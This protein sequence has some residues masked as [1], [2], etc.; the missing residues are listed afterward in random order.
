MS[1]YRN[2]II[3]SVL[4]LFA[5][6]CQNSKNKQEEQS[7]ESIVEV[8]YEYGIPVDSFDMVEGSVGKGETLSAIFGRL[9]CNGQVI[10]QLNDFSTE[11]FDVKRIKQGGYVTI[12]RQAQLARH[13]VGKAHGGYIVSVDGN[14]RLVAYLPLADVYVIAVS[15]VGRPLYH[16]PFIEFLD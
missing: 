9:G 11:F 16:A 3:I 1:L 13:L 12:L 8:V 6:A 7:Q 15:E 2:L 14:V 5:S 10:H 4:A